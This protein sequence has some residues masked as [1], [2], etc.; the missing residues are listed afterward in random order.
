RASGSGVCGQ[1]N[2]RKKD[3]HTALRAIRFASVS[4]ISRRGKVCKRAAGDLQ[5][6]NSVSG[7]AVR[8][9]WPAPERVAQSLWAYRSG[10][11]CDLLGLRTK[12]WQKKRS[13]RKTDREYANLRA[14]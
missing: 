6:R 14:G 11:G 13:D 4:G 7:F 1:G 12:S 8:L 2:S 3:H 10:G 5:R 9:L